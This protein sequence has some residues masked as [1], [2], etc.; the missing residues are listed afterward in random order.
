MR[1]DWGWLWPRIKTTSERTYFP[2]IGGRGITL[3]NSV[4]LILNDWAQQIGSQGLILLR[5]YYERRAVTDCNSPCSSCERE[6][7][8]LIPEDIDAYILYLKSGQVA[9]CCFCTLSPVVSLDW[10]LVSLFL[11]SASPGVSK[12]LSAETICQN[13][14]RRRTSSSEQKS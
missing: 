14:S 3:S 10:S 8:P 5:N 13:R 2:S 11:E 9:V 6:V 1:D 7:W 4:N 12:P